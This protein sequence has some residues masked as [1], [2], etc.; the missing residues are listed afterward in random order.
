MS[1]SKLSYWDERYTKDKESFD[2][3]QHWA[4]FKDVLSQHIN[5]S[6]K[7]LVHGCGNAAMSEDMHTDGYKTITGVDFS[8]VVIEGQKERYR[9]LAGQLTWEQQ[10]ITALEFKDDQF[11]SCI[12]KAAMDALLC[13]E[14]SALNA[15]NM[16]KEVI[17]VLKPEGVFIVISYDTP[18]NRLRYLEKEEY[19][20]TVTVQK[21]RKPVGPEVTIDENAP[22]AFHYIYICKR[23]PMVAEAEESLQL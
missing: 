9:H 10:D 12:N 2:W 4:G 19:D 17:R 8:R 5:R 6:D 11:E 20:W 16:C 22:Q 1:P 15:H 14:G 3:Y 23:N 13:G 18:I 7:I 21:V